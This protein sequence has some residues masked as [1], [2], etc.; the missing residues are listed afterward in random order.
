MINPTQNQ[1]F[2]ENQIPANAP[3]NQKN[4]IKTGV[5]VLLTIVVLVGVLLFGIQIGQKR[6]VNNII[7]V[8]QPKII[9][10]QTTPSTLNNTTPTSKPFDD[11][12][13]SGNTSSNLVSSSGFIS[14]SFTMPNGY[15]VMS[16]ND[17]VKTYG[18]DDFEYLTI[19]KGVTV[20]LNQLSQKCEVKMSGFCL[21]E[22]SN[23]GQ[24]EKVKNMT[25]DGVPARSFYISGGVDNA[26]HV[27]QTTTD[28]KIELKMYVA[29]GGLDSTFQNILTS[30]KL[31][32]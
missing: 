10:S 1:E 6:V 32:K 24:N 19:T 27:V 25:L 17:V 4:Y 2:V 3:V 31:E 20:D 21:D 12:L 7:G 29:G 9:T 22:G 11:E 15:K 28:P 13:A 26:F 23:W 18:F 14:Y 8:G 5:K 30:F 16:T